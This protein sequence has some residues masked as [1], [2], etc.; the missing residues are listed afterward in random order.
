MPFSLF[1]YLK[2]KPES[3]NAI[4]HKR[5]SASVLQ[6]SLVFSTVIPPEKDLNSMGWGKQISDLTASSKHQQN[7]IYID[8]YAKKTRQSLFSASA[9]AQIP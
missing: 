6:I 7:Y 2:A 8:S 1:A 3:F 9:N 4:K 5:I